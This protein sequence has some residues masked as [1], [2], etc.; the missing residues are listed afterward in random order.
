MLEAIRI[1]SLN[2][3]IIFTFHQRNCIIKKRENVVFNDNDHFHN[4]EFYNVYY[5][6]FVIINAKE[7]F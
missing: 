2:V 5:L 7:M 6:K 3:K 4:H 1:T